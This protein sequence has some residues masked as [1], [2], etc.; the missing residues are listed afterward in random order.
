MIISSLD[1]HFV[2]DLFLHFYNTYT[3]VD[4]SPFLMITCQWFCSFIFSFILSSFIYLFA[5]IIYILIFHHHSNQICFN[6]HHTQATR[7]SCTTRVSR[8]VN[9]KHP[10]DFKFLTFILTYCFVFVFPSFESFDFLSILYH[11]HNTFMIYWFI[12]FL[13]FGISCVCVSSRSRLRLPWDFELIFSFLLFAG[14]PAAVGAN[15]T[16]TCCRLFFCLPSFFLSFFYFCVSLYVELWR[17]LTHR[18]TDTNIGRFQ[19]VLTFTHECVR[20][21]HFFLHDFIFF[22]LCWLRDL[23]ITSWNEACLLLSLFFQFWLVPHTHT[24]LIKRNEQ[25]S[26]CGSA[27]AFIWLE[28]SLAWLWPTLLYFIHATIPPAK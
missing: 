7:A 10:S 24:D 4:S 6:V 15:M 22:F 16:H 2:V 20:F 21:F 9:P 18:H 28:W 17:T 1:C 13:T 25:K 5:S 3:G 26:K 23:P 19:L 14:K 8:S 12:S 11:T 27:S